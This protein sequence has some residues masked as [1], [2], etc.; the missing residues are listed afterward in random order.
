MLIPDFLRYT[1]DHLWIDLKGEVAKIGLT[2]YA[3][4]L[5]GTI[6]FIELPVESSKLLKHEKL[7]TIEGLKSVI[8]I[9]SPFDC[10]VIRANEALSKEPK[11]INSQ[12]YDNGWICEATIADTIDAESLLAASDYET[13]FA[14]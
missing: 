12:P 10:I 8:E 9:A 1:S 5:L 13:R 6:S 3:Q 4:E 2:D 11:L 14:R 7:A